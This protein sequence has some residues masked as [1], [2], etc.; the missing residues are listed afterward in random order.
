MKPDASFEAA[1]PVFVWGGAEQRR[2]FRP[3]IALSSR[4][5]LIV[6]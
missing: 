6:R 1:H 5:D 3:L 2:V 4:A